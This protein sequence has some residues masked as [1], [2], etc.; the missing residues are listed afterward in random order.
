MAFSEQV[1]GGLPL[2]GAHLRGVPY[3]I[4]ISAASWRTAPAVCLSWCVCVCELCSFVNV[5]STLER[6]AAKLT[7]KMHVHAQSCA[8]PQNLHFRDHL[9]VTGRPKVSFFF[10]VWQS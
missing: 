3:G 1:T 4:S 6:Q 7:I 9:A 5:G 10:L 8:V 2:A